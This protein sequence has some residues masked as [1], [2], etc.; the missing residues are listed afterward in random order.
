MSTSWLSSHVWPGLPSEPRQ[1][2]MFVLMKL[3][4]QAIITQTLFVCLRLD[5]SARLSPPAPPPPLPLSASLNGCSD[6][7]RRPAGARPCTKPVVPGT[8]WT[9]LQRFLPN[10]PDSISGPDGE[11]SNPPLSWLGAS[12]QVFDRFNSGPW[13]PHLDHFQVSTVKLFRQDFTQTISR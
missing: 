10:Q 9:Q 11:I 1:L 5:S 3:S 13:L 7:S 6:Q 2:R 12:F 4:A 8:L